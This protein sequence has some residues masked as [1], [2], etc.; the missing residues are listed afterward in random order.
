MPAGRSKT[1]RTTPKAPGSRLEVD[2]TRLMRFVH[3]Y[4]DWTL[5]NAS[6]ARPSLNN[7]ALP[8]RTVSCLQRTTPQSATHAETASH[9]TS[10]TRCTDSE[11]LVEIGDDRVIGKAGC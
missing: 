2:A 3:P 9:P 4:R 7:E 6:T 1:G 5:R 11:S 8:M 10:R